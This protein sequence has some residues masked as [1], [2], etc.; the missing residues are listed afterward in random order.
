MKYRLFFF[1]LLLWSAAD[2]QT[3]ESKVKEFDAYVEKSRNLYEV[4]GLAITVVKDGKVILKKGYGVRQLG[5]TNA[6]DTQTLFACASTTKAMTATC[7]AMLVDEGKV[8]WDDPV[9]NY[10]PEFQLYDPSVT[11]EIKIRDLFTHNTG[12]GNADFFW[13][14]M[15]I[16]SDE[17]LKKMKLVK[18]SYSLRS[19][20]IYQNIFYLY[21]GKVIEKVSGL[22]WEEFIQK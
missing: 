19:S 17:I 7:M 4:P 20:F 12:I 16:P 5:T 15:H 22:S 13:G 9:I 14:S 8:K 21:A 3:I 2:A 6:V 1:L 10:L 18:P 11:R